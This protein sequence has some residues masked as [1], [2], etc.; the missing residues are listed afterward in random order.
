[1]SGIYWLASYPKSGNTWLRL[2]LRSY[3]A[4]GTAVDINA[5]A[6][7]GWS[8][9]GRAQFDAA[10]GVAASDLT[11]AGI[12]AWWPS[13]LRYWTQTRTAPAYLKTH[14]L[15]QPLDVT[16][17]AVYLVRDPRDVAL[18][19][20]RQAD[21]SIDAAIAI[22]GTPD[23]IMGRSRDRLQSRLAQFWGSWS[24][25]VESWLAPAPFSVH[26][27][28]YE[29]MRADPVAALS[30]LL[31]ALGFSVD[32][33]AVEAAVAATAL[34]SLRAQE[35]AMGFV[36]AEGPHPF[37]GEGRVAG[38]R[39]RLTPAQRARIEADHGQVMARLGYID[40]DY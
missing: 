31:P 2:L 32:Q 20:A 17:G 13:A 14:D 27:L 36:E 28:S 21:S 18:S 11:D 40:S 38:W 8:L 6:P 19:L 26:V 24:Q 4:G 9:N 23:K 5:P 39:T 3:L 25:N 15:C 33:A 12:L 1:M 30:G 37:F 22:M 34:K 16:L 29:A 35:A 7:D 10:I